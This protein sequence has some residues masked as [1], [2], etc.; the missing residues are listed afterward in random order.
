MDVVSTRPR[1]D[2][3]LRRAWDKDTRETCRWLVCNSCRGLRSLKLRV[4]FPIKEN[5]SRGKGERAR[6]W[7]RS[8]LMEF[9][10]SR[11]AT[12]YERV[13]RYSNVQSPPPRWKNR[14]DRWL[15][16]KKRLRNSCCPLD[17]NISMDSALHFCGSL[18]T[19][20]NRDVF[21]QGCSPIYWPV[22]RNFEI[23]RTSEKR[24]VNV[25]VAEMTKSRKKDGSCV[26]YAERNRFLNRS[27]RIK[28]GSPAVSLGRS[29]ET[30]IFMPSK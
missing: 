10:P 4:Y 15:A 25:R 21:V 29:K 19:E 3:S 17:F 2:F 12:I 13:S 28:S 20:L 6:D 18:H 8:P 7:Y 11:T 9:T 26:N 23:D 24:S 14:S 30:P 16:R 27:V 5:L 1:K 22:L